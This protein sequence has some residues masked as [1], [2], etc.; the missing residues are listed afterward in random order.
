MASLAKKVPNAKSMKIF[1]H[2]SEIGV[3]IQLRIRTDENNIMSPGRT[4]IT[5]TLPKKSSFRVD[6]IQL[7]VNIRWNKGLLVPKKS[8]K[9]LKQ[10]I[11]SYSPPFQYIL[12]YKR[13]S[14]EPQ[15][16]R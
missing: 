12:R 11:T 9:Y 13:M 4:K 15:S 10:T 6:Q 1:Y 5:F 8:T 16:I 2:W 7:G 14:F 3:V